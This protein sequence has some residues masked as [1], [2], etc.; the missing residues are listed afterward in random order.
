MLM[1]KERKS[2]ENRRIEASN[3]LVKYRDRIPIICE[4]QPSCTNLPMIDKHKYLVPRDLTVGQFQYV[5]RKRLHITSEQAI[6]LFT[7]N[8][9]LSP[10]ARTLSEL[11]EHRK[12]DDGFLYMRYSGENTFGNDCAHWAPLV[13]ARHS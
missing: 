10:T 3:I 11:Y 1:F 5:L 9:Q 4:R 2:F 7:D 12:D 13:R 6:F 8:G